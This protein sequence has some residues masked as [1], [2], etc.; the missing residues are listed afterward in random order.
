MTVTTTAIRIDRPA[1][2]LPSTA[3]ERHRIAWA[4]REQ[5]GEWFLL[6]AAGTP[7]SAQTHAWQIRTAGK[8]WAMFGDGFEAEA[9]TMLGQYRVYARW[10]DTEAVES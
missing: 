8:G 7:K 3:P 10:A 2:P 4:L 9:R 6:G 1:D 5:P